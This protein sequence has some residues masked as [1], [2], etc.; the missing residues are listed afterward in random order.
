MRKLSILISFV[1]SFSALAQVKVLE[2]TEAQNLK[3]SEVTLETSCKDVSFGSDP[4][5]IRYDC[6]VGTI[7]SF[8]SKKLGT[9][10][11]LQAMDSL[12]ESVLTNQVDNE[13]KY[14]VRVRA[15]FY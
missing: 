13:G 5:A 9:V 6:K 11:R 4:D 12:S 2:T 8:I 7:K 1:I 14:T 10:V 3:I 15:Y